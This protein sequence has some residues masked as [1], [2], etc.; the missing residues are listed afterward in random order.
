M[1]ETCAS[2]TLDV[3]AA[4][5]MVIG[6]NYKN[7][8]GGNNTENVGAVSFLASGGPQTIKVS[9]AILRQAPIH[10]TVSGYEEDIKGG[11][12]EAKL[13]DSSN[14]GISLSAIAE[15]RGITG[16]SNSTE[17]FKGIDKGY[18][19][20]QEPTAIK[21]WAVGMVSSGVDLQAGGPQTDA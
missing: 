7:E 15:T 6:G 10:L 20:K 9:G 4:R 12:A 5:L 13:T 1:N 19:N 3:S 16:L 8:I 17:V 21:L 11:F 18:K 2:H 14:T